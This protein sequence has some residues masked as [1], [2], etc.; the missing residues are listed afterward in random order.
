[1]NRKSLAHVGWMLALLVCVGLLAPAAARA[2]GFITPWY[3]ADFAGDAGSCSSVVACEKKQQTFGGSIGFM[4][5]GIF[6]LEGDFG[7]APHFF[8][9]SSDR[10]DN[11][12]AT[13]MANLLIGAPIGPIRP[14]AVGG[15][16]LLHTNAS[17]TS[18]A[19]LNAVSDN[20]V[21]FDVGGGVMVFFSDHVGIRGD[22][23]Y[24]RSFNATSLTNFNLSDKN[25]DFWRG[26]LGLS[27]R[28]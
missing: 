15:V 28:F 27:L 19:L 24:I 16:G 1:M 6:G 21:A 5:G 12:V 17:V 10:G 14:Y 2:D 18:S 3:G 4:L 25:I 26:S 23:R 22:A 20:N 9:E 11:Y 7:Y 13:V 8:G